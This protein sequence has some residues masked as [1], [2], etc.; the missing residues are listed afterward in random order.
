MA[1]AI[2]GRVARDTRLGEFLQ[3]R[4]A[5]LSPEAAGIA[6]YGR[7]RVPGLRR[8][9][10]AQL[11]GVSV[12]YYVRLE[13]GRAA[14]PSA[15][16]LDAIAR[17]LQLEEAERRH[18]HEL[19]APPR[20]RRRAPARERVLPGLLR[21]LDRLD[22]VPAFVLGRQMD[23]LAWN[24]LAA[25][26]MGDPGRLPPER[27]NQAWMMFLDPASRD[28]YADWERCA[29]ET[30]GY[31]RHCAG[32]HPDDPR[33][34]ALVGELS[35]RSEP[36]ARWWADH[37]VREKASGTKRYRHPVVGDLTLGFETL[38]PPGA[39]DQ[40]LIT[41]TAEPGSA[42][43]TALRLLAAWAAPA[44]EERVTAR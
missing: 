13:Q 41:Y 42:S 4:R 24:R 6:A 8:E 43:E 34:A 7:R 35:V 23:I 16:V 10:L 30:V 12:D 1:F 2:L 29:R 38:V 5:L 18:M 25:A 11:A 20:A 14:H 40:A 33:I 27:R 39:P 15:E 32:R 44:T 22:G 3:A 17:A 26:L 36:F 21:L 31:L 37:L 28:L 19:A 9:E